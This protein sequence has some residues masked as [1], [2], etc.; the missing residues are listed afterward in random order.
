MGAANASDDEIEIST[1]KPIIVDID[2]IDNIELDPLHNPGGNDSSNLLLK[3]SLGNSTTNSDCDQTACVVESGRNIPGS[4][5]EHPSPR[6]MVKSDTYIMYYFTLLF[7]LC[8]ATPVL[9]T[10]SLNVY[11]S[12][13]VRSTAYDNIANHQWLT[14]AACV[15]MWSPCLLER[16]MSKWGV[17]SDRLPVS[18]FLFLLGH[19]HN[20]LRS[21][22]SYFVSMSKFL[23]SRCV[24]H[25][26]FAQQSYNSLR[27][28]A[29]LMSRKVS[30]SLPGRGFRIRPA[31][32]KK[33]RMV[34]NED[35]APAPLPPCS[36]KRKDTLTPRAPCAGGGT[37]Q[38]G[39][40]ATIPT[41]TIVESAS[42]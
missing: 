23:P 18:V 39:R 34:G 11:I 38:P 20:L 26:V 7:M 19:T 33:V 5:S 22:I 40:R 28:G 16:M 32:E 30:W 31:P 21:D 3:S 42:L 24:L 9:I 41:I 29:K 14:L 37:P 4:E 13:A 10:T 12:S 2:R 6:C 27:P 35:R 1:E 17:I 8:F 25:A 36:L 15:M